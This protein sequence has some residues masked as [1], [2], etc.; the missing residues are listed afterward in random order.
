M[1]HDMDI[2]MGMV[3]VESHQQLVNVDVDDDQH[4]IFLLFWENQHEQW[5]MK[6]EITKTEGTQQDYS[7][8]LFIRW[9]I[10]IWH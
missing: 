10:Q 5:N 4:C 3:W 2:S 8:K 6:H 9:T 1:R 7:V